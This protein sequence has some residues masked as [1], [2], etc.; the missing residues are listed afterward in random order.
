MPCM[1]ILP[2]LP[3]AGWVF[4]G[5]PADWMSVALHA[6]HHGVHPAANQ[7]SEIRRD[8]AVAGAGLPANSRHHLGA[9]NG[10]KWAT[11]GPPRPGI[12]QPDR[13]EFP[14]VDPGTLA[15]HT[16]SAQA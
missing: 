2:K 15:S 16:E 13:A 1:T 8:Q 9:T 3:L 6:R 4:L 7:L 10:H 11:N 14:P 5:T 12:L